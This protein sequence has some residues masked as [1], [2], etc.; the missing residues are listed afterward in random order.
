[1]ELNFDSFYGY[2]RKE[3]NLDLNAYKEGQLQR[4][5]T[6]VMKSAGA[7]NLEEY[8][9]LITKDEAIKIKFLD[10][11]TINVTEF[12]R[13]KDI[14]TEFEKIL[15]NYLS[16]KFPDI[17]IWSAAC[18]IGAE[19]YSLSIILDKNNIKMREKI[20]ATDIDDKILSRAKEGLYKD[21]EIKNI[22]KDDLNKYF[23]KNGDKFLIK[24]SVKERVTFKKHD[25]ILDNYQ[26]G[27]HAIICR[28]VTIYFKN[29]AKDEIYKKFSESLVKGGVLFTGATETIYNPA[30]FGLKKISTFIYEKI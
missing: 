21:F 13:N 9:K 4:R 2:V 26:K 15:I 28:N 6:T 30:E 12:F 25:L 27:F 19:P 16:P 1:M 18:S 3:L 20:L 22:D 17:K 29:E 23:V 5:I 14:F 10:Y 11:I 24:D 7:S 8:S